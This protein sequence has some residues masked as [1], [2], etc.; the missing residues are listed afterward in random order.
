MVRHR[1]TKAPDKKLIPDDDAQR[2]L[3]M[4]RRALIMLKEGSFSAEEKQLIED[5]ITEW[6]RV[7]KLGIALGIHFTKHDYRNFMMKKLGAK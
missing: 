1:T 4:Q 5:A 7:Y 6:S 2:L 3:L